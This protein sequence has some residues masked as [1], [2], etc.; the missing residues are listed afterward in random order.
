[1]D[2]TS[3]N[4]PDATGLGPG[5]SAADLTAYAVKRGLGVSDERKLAKELGLSLP[6]ARNILG[7][8]EDEYARQLKRSK[9]IA[10]YGS[11]APH[12]SRPRRR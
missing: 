10:G 7:L 3:T 5:S 8:A 11:K 2:M 9:E 4:K 12:S 1:M 6:H